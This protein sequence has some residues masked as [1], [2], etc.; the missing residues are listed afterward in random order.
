MKQ[1]ISAAVIYAMTS[2]VLA[3]YFDS[4]YGAGPVTHRLGLIH[5]AFAGALLFVVACAMSL[6]AL[7]L[8][9]ACGVVAS[10]LSWPYFGPRLLAIPWSRFIQVLPHAMWADTYAAIL[11]LIISSAYSAI[12]LRLLLR[13]PATGGMSGS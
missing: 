2:L 8:G 6:F 1:R 10:I 4:L 5:A 9:V 11:M 12:R 3:G 13:A 7:R